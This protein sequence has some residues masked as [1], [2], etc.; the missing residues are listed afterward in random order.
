LRAIDIEET[1]R[2]HDHTTIWLACLCGKDGF[3]LGHVVD[4]C[5]DLLQSQGRGGGFEWLEINVAIWRRGRIE[6]ERGPVDARPNLLEQLQPLAGNGR[7]HNGETGGVAGRPR[8]TLNETA[9]DRISN[10]HKYDGDSTRLF[11]H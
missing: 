2:H 3:E 9:A 6:Q 11:Q 4:R 5:S 7:L 1:I 10:N 8:Q